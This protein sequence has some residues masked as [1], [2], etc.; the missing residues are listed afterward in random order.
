MKIRSKKCKNI[1]K[2]GCIPTFY[3]DSKDL[4]SLLELINGSIDAKNDNS[5]MKNRGMAILDELLKL[6][7][8]SKD[9]QEK[10]YIGYLI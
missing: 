3:N 9:Q 5:K 1:I 4:L 7:A 6:G 8:I 10:L 2:G